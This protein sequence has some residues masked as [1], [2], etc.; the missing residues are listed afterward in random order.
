MRLYN[1]T[2]R[3]ILYCD[4][5]KSYYYA[6]CIILLLCR[7]QK[8]ML[9]FIYVFTLP[10]KISFAIHVQHYSIMCIRAANDRRQAEEVGSQ[11]ELCKL[12][13]EGLTPATS[14]AASLCAAT[15][16]PS[17]LWNLN[18]WYNWSMWE[19]SYWRRIHCIHRV[20]YDFY[21]NRK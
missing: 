2:L 3:S 20:Y 9:I 13:W 21:S 19:R 12:K 10:F 4:T 18:S 1:H 15:S 7:F 17:F 6:L 5:L 11:E 14:A 8:L 16:P